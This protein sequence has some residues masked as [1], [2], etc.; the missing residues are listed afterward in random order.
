LSQQSEV[1]GFTVKCAFGAK[2]QGQS[3][4]KAAANQVALKK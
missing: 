1:V 2:P 3:A 4:A